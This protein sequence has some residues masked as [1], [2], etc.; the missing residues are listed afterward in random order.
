MSKV[1]IIGCG[2]VGEAIANA[3]VI[4]DAVSDLVLS[5]VAKDK[6]QGMAMDFQHGQDFHG[7]RVRA[8]DGW[9]DTANSDVVIITAG[10]RQRPDE[11]RRDLMGRNE[12]IMASFVPAMAAASPNAI[13][14][15]V[16]NPCDLVSAARQ[17]LRAAAARRAARRSARDRGRKR[18]RRT[19]ESV[20]DR[21]SPLPFGAR[22]WPSSSS[23]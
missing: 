17:P 13:V 7:T 14:I 20:P 6:L 15:V 3:L 9:D 19:E 18:N 1:T 8:A 16:A 5:D 22:R 21:L 23:R 2:A 4:A 11:S 10:V 12:A